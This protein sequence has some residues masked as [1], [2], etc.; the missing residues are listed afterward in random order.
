M[1][2]PHPSTGM[3][4]VYIEENPEHNISAAFQD[5][6]PQIKS[7]PVPKTTSSIASSPMMT[8]GVK[9]PSVVT[10]FVYVLH[11]FCISVTI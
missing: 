5:L 6:V 10:G 11:M 3:P 4:G 8:N 9:S 1:P 2:I 7:D